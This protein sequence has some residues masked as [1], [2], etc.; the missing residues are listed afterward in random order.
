[1]KKYFFGLLCAIIVTCIVCIY[2]VGGQVGAYAWNIAVFIFSPVAIFL[3][4]VQIIILIVSLCKGKKVAWNIAF[5]AIS[6]VFTLPITVLLGVS[7]ITYPTNATTND[8]ISVKMP[9]ENAVIF[10]GNEYK[11]HAMWPSECYAYD[12]LK[13]PYNVESLNVHDY[14]IFGEDIISPVKGRVIGIE[15]NEQDI[16]PNTEEF[17]SSLGN[18]IFIEIE[19]TNTYL[20]L[21]HLMQDSIGVL[22]GEYIDEGEVIGKVGNSGTT[23]EP[24]LHIQH[25]RNN[26]LEMKFPV[27]SEGLPITFKK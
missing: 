17:T 13:E 20:I 4:L 27:C 7:P 16:I 23:S 11:I 22:V 2:C 15:N 6:I 25:Q 12:I 14:G 3:I 10:G 19:E 18:Y 1:M 26:P 5:I 8:S 21:A 24:H 9:I